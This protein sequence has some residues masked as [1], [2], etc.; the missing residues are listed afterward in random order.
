MLDKR[1]DITNNNAQLSRYRDDL[2]DADL[3]RG[4]VRGG[5]DKMKQLKH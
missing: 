2:L 4:G 5:D 3:P 1:H